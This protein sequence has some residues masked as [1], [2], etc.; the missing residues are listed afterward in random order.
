MSANAEGCTYPTINLMDGDYV[1]VIACVMFAAVVG[2]KVV[3]KAQIQ[4]V[5]TQR[6]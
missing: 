4:S 1:S 3:I 5:S 2:S 6:Q